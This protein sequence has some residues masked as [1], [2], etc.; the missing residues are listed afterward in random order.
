MGAG[1][2]VDDP[3][4]IEKGVQESEADELVKRAEGIIDRCGDE[5]KAVFLD[6][7]KSLMTA[8]L[9]LK[10]SKESDFQ[11]LYSEFLDFLEA[12]EL[13]FHHAFRRLGY[14]RLDEIESEERRKDVAGRFFRSGEAPRQEADS[15]ERIG[16]WLEKWSAR[17]KEDWGE[18]NDQERQAAMARMNPKVCCI[19]N[20]EIDIC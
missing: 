11:E 2:K 18:E 5:Y 16:K 6:H 17:V 12:F 3:T 1:P 15:R 8:R 4:Y 14:I 13:D 7:Y 9:G 20:T 19:N 10:T